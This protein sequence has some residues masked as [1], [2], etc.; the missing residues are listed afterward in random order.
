MASPHIQG[1]HCRE[2]GSLRTD[3]D[4]IQH[5]QMTVR[6]II[7]AHT[8]EIEALKA[9]F[10]ADLERLQAELDAERNARVI[11]ERREQWQEYVG[12]A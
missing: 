3:M 1:S 2:L 7:N 9:S 10:R 11:R 4:M 6:E 12:A 8:A 5:E